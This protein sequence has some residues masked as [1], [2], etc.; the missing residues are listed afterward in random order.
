MASGRSISTK[1]SIEGERQYKAAITSINSE[2]RVLKSEMTA[3][4]AEF[5][6]NANSEAALSSK[7][8]TLT[9]TLDKQREKVKTLSDAVKAGKQAQENWKT[10]IEQTKKDLQEA[11]DKIS[12]LDESTANSGKQWNEYKTKLDAANQE[13]K[14]LKATEGD[15]TEQQNELQAEIK[16][17]EAEMG[18]LNESTGGTAEETGKLYD[19]QAELNK[20][21]T[22]QEGKLQSATEKTN[23]W[24]I[25]LNNARATE[26]NLNV[27]TQKTKKYLDEAKQSTDHCATSIDKFG[28]ETKEA[29]D[30]LDEAGE[31]AGKV[32]DA[33]Q[34]LSS[35]LMTVGL[36]RGIKKIV[37]IL[38]ECVEVSAD[39][40]YTL[41]TV[42]AVTG[43]TSEEIGKLEGQAREY[44][45]STI[46]SAQDIAESYEVMGRAGWTTTE[47]LDSMQG[48]M[49]L[50][51]SAGEDLSSTTNIVVDAMTAFGYSADQAGH[52]ADVLAQTAADSNTTV[53]L[54]GNSFQACATTAGAMGYTVDDVAL[55]LGI[56]AN[57]GL[58][59]ETAGTALT[60]ALT[61]MSGANET[62][63]GAMEN[64][65]L[66]MFDTSG[67]AK[68]LGKFL[69]ELRD[70]FAGMTEEEKVNNAY[71][72]AGQ[73]G[74]KGLLAIVNSSEEDWNALTE[75]I[76]DCSGAADEMSNIQLDTY[77]GQVKV[78]KNAME[79]L[80]I[81]VGDKLTPALGKLA[82]GFTG[83]LNGI[84]GFVENTEIA[85]PV[86]MGAVTALGA[87]TTAITV[88]TVAVKAFEA[89]QGALGTALGPV[90]LTVGAISIALGV[91][92]SAFMETGGEE[93]NF[94]ATH[95]ATMDSIGQE[96]DNISALVARLTELTSKSSANAAE[97]K[98]ISAIVSTLNGKIPDLALEYDGLSNSV[99]L[100]TD[101]ILAAAQ[102]MANQDKIE[103]DYELLGKL[104]EKMADAQDTL[105]DSMGEA[106]AA[107]TAYDDAL[108]EY[109]NHLGESPSTVSE[110]KDALNDAKEDMEFWNDQVERDT[111][112]VNGY[113]E[114][115]DATTSEIQE[116]SGGT[117]DAT[118]ATE[119]LGDE[120]N[121]TS[122][123]M[124]KLSEKTAEANEKMND[125]YGETMAA[126]ESGTDLRD[127]YDDLKKT[128]EQYKDKAD[129]ATVAMV[130]Q[131][132]AQL[133]L[134]A[135]NQE[136][137]D[138]YGY[139]VSIV[140]GMG[141]PLENLSQWL[142]DNEITAD[143]WG[144]GVGSAFDNVVNGFEKLDTSLDMN[145]STM[146]SN[147]QSNITAY[148]NWN[149]N[150]QT[151]M[152]AAV[153][154]GDANAIKFVQVMQNMGIGAADQVASMAQ[155]I[156]WTFDTF[157]PMMDQAG[158]E[159]VLAYYLGIENNKQSGVDVMTGV[160]TDAANALTETDMEGAGAET[161]EQA[162]AGMEGQ[163]DTVVNAA[164]T[165]ADAAVSGVENKAPDFKTAG[166]KWVTQIKVGM[167]TNKNSVS[168][169]AGS[170]ANAASS[171]INSVSWYNL[172]WNISS[173]VARGVSAASYLIKRAAINAAQSAYNAAKET[174]GIHSPSR[175][176]AEIGRYYDE[177]F[178]RG[179]TEN[180]DT[181]T[182]AAQ[183]MAKESAYT[184]TTIRERSGTAARAADEADETWL[185]DI[186]E[187]YLPEMLKAMKAGKSISM[188][189]LAKAISPYVDNDLGQ[190][191]RR[192]NRGN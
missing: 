121:A 138:S 130:E 46:F 173:G 90:G 7:M 38:K 19:K 105:A 27:E 162:A 183:A 115:I 175:V 157:G 133:N 16:Q 166:T 116:L 1:V 29:A 142:I 125:L 50:A 100:S 85:A 152:D 188:K 83:V 96:S 120:A 35:L 164:E 66:S 10:T 75:S 109:N 132:L 55:A 53:A 131:Q 58:K 64:L 141:V 78:M 26:A 42:Q 81:A 167:L 61:R 32:G 113:Q 143:E 3:V 187:K 108:V 117:S 192:K 69:N 23:R 136:L 104:Q 77:T 72:L 185:R 114:E 107:Q 186:L 119:G 40:H 87:F 80:Q 95:Q 93:E 101:A 174:L 14:A 190:T 97:Q 180:V 44:A 5:Q 48:T 52:F 54:L 189:E 60:T 129:E 41:A 79:D 170:V 145:L 103:E 144:K 139:Y 110:Y 172:G 62:A 34:T 15:T 82:E 151:L 134:L 127:K 94:R 168:V 18:K 148:Q 171:A 11:N 179:I 2:L 21:L 4:T 20:N 70:A 6:Q 150:I 47:M 137:A 181:V 84:T 59:A 74:M 89:V 49:S 118:D 135:T 123:D 76:A 68:P 146:A 63:S 149:T 43:E 124:A 169:A 91:A 102:A 8:E 112:A 155:N 9:R 57:S 67:Q 30:K 106:A 161:M 98:E 111:E 36:A 22:T 45:S 25:Q 165:V 28:K 39:F 160:G 86:V 126:I 56:M 12:T 178:A 158:A 99:N 122:E 65:G 24:Q 182:K 153:A 51:A 31:G 71:M 140:E 37:D 184:P 154:S 147:L 176:M 13:M 33:F 156:Q 159:A 163:T 128:F 191:E 73:R 177:G 17:L 92:A 88:A